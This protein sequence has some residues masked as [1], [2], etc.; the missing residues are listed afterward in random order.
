MGDPNFY[1]RCCSN[2]QR[3]IYVVYSC[4]SHARRSNDFNELVSVVSLYRGFFAFNDFNH[5]AFP[6]RASFAAC[7][8]VQSPF[9]WR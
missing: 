7:S 9:L 8:G 1:S 4:Y 2:V 3:D 5:L 6:F